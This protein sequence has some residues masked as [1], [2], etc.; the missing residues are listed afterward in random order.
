MAFRRGVN[1]AIEDASRGDPGEKS[2][3]AARPAHAAATNN[4]ADR[5]VASPRIKI[6]YG[7][8]PFVGVWVVSGHALLTKVNSWCR[9]RSP[10]RG[11]PRRHCL[12]RHGQRGNPWPS[13]LEPLAIT[14]TAGA[15]TLH[16]GNL[17]DSILGA[18]GADL[19]HGGDG[20]DTLNGAVHADTLVGGNGIDWA[21]YSTTTLAIRIALSGTLMGGGGAQGD[22]LRE[23][24]NLL[25]TAFNDSVAG[26]G[27]AN[28]VSGQAGNDTLT[29]GE[30]DDTLSGGDGTDSILGDAGNDSIDG[31]VARDLLH[32]GAGNDTITGGEGNDLIRGDDGNDS[33]VGGT[34]N[35]MILG[36]FG[37]DTLTGL[38]GD[39]TLKGEEGN[40][41]ITGGLGNDSVVGGRGDDTAFGGDGNDIMS[42]GSGDDL[43]HGEGGADKLY[44]GIGRDSLDGG[45]GNDTLSG[46]VND[47]SI[48]GGANNDLILGDL[49]DLTNRDANNDVAARGWTH[50]DSTPS[51]GARNVLMISIDDLNAWVV[52]PDLY[53]GPIDTPNMDALFGSGVLFRDAHAQLPICN[54]SRVSALT[55]LDPWRTGVVENLT[56]W[57]DL[58]P[59]AI[60]LPRYFK[61]HGYETV[62]A[63]KIFHVDNDVNAQDPK[64]WSTIYAEPEGTKPQQ[65]LARHTNATWGLNASAETLPDYKIASFAEQYLAQAPESPFFLAVGFR[66]PHGPWYLPREYYDRNP[67]D[68]IA[69]PKT[70][71]ADLLDVP[72]EGVRLAQTTT[73]TANDDALV[74]KQAVQAY[75]AAISYVDDQIGRV[76][77]ALANSGKA[78]NT[79]IALWSDNGFHMGEK[80][81]F[82]KWTLWNESTN[83]PFAIA[84]PGIEPGTVIDT[85]VGLVDMFAT[86]TD[87][88]GLPRLPGTDSQSLLP[89]I[90]HPGRPWDRPALSM[91]DGSMSVRT[92][93]YH[94]IRYYDGTDEL[95]DAV[96]DPHEFTNLAELP[97]YATVVRDLASWLPS[98]ADTLSG[99]DGNDTIQAGAGDDI[100]LGGNGADQLAAGA[101]ADTVSGG[102]GNDTIRGGHGD[103][104]VHGGLGRDQLEGGPGR[105]AFVFR[106][107]LESTVGPRRDTIVDFEP[108]ND[109]FV[110]EGMLSGG[111]Q[112]RGEGPLLAGASSQSRYV[113]ST[114]VIQVDVD[115]GG[116]VDIEIRLANSPGSAS[117]SAS[118][119]VWT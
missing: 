33:L 110:L 30:G 71:A 57:K 7:L 84:G 37:N 82:G 26:D 49:I 62:S 56:D 16:G 28:W 70:L 86:L 97:A 17:N 102:D 18:A 91:V 9:E 93:A 63:G 25:A 115:G 43:V 42:G 55:G 105:D 58:V 99:G 79:V 77:D 107:P 74:Y 59:D 46:S 75:L 5:R 106:Q 10:Y 111:F 117:F 34:G 50:V 66:K 8:P 94:Y 78:G 104:T 41:S 113:A 48:V 38:D 108:G 35:D 2:D 101:G 73:S 29:G 109:R 20:N 13:S 12:G 3:S 45:V 80:D 118:D 87:L 98:G 54:A 6:S 103:D 81:H 40:D 83:V 1:R 90:E 65:V 76:M 52:R 72:A 14:G 100:V 36:W 88:D 89:L 53:D 60:T 47:D 116:S 32:G 22:R 51:A 69:L 31:G 68:Q 19:L 119:F 61:D 64:A 39:D 15:D 11:N 85:P 92:D 67:L 24:E 112:W 23:I 4:L 114:G 44:S 21:D 96:S 27:A 95:Y